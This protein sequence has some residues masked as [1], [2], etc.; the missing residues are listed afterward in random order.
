ML[1]Q[2]DISVTGGL[3][4]RSRTLVGPEGQ[5]THTWLTRI[6][7]R[8][9][10]LGLTPLSVLASP[11]VALSKRALRNPRS[12]KE[13]DLLLDLVNV[14]LCMV[15]KDC[16]A[17]GRVTHVLK[18]YESSFPVHSIDIYVLCLLCKAQQLKSYLC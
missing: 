1:Q 13:S 18:L 14:Y 9:T 2:N 3:Y 12:K 6:P 17:F 10:H 4:F 11:R 15:L 5:S 16:S 7:H 8:Q